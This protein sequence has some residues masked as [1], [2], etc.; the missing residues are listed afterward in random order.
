VSPFRPVRFIVLRAAK[1]GRAEI[2]STIGLEHGTEPAQNGQGQRS[3]NATLIRCGPRSLPVQLRLVV[4]LRGPR[5]NR[6]LD[7]L[8]HYTSSS[9]ALSSSSS[10]AFFVACCALLLRSLLSTLIDGE[11]VYFSHRS[12][13]AGSR[14]MPATTK[15]SKN[16]KIC[17]RR[18]CEKQIHRAP[19]SFRTRRMATGRPCHSRADWRDTR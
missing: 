12:F 10:L 4:S 11:L 8:R 13:R 18:L 15:S 5:L 16:V 6:A 1:T 14:R 17:S 2:N 7:V 3:G 19:L 9:I